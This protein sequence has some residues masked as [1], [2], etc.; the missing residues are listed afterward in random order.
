MTCVHLH[1]NVGGREAEGAMYRCTP[2]P[3][4]FICASAFTNLI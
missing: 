3:E 4:T 1:E 2:T